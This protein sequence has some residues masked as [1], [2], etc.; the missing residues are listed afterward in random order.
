VLEGNVGM[1]AE[2]ERCTGTALSRHRDET[3]LH[4]KIRQD[5]IKEQQK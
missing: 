4:T 3:Y 5:S 2:V 1:I